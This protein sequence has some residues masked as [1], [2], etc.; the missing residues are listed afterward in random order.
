MNST[1]QLVLPIIDHR[2]CKG[3][4]VCARRCPTQAIAVTHG[5]AVVIF[6]YAC[7]FCDICESYCPEGAIGRPFTVRF[8]TG[9]KR[10]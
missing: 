6:P 4:G 8:E 9:R 3:C 2:R 1:H 10:S 5:K 7:T